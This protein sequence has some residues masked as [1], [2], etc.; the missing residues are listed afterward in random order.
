MILLEPFTVPGLDKALLELLITAGVILA[1]GVAVTVGSIIG[2]IRALRRQRRGDRSLAA[3]V[4]A[5]TAF[6][7][8]LAW[9]LYW[10]RNDLHD[11]GNPVNAMFA[12]NAA[13]CVLPLT[14]LVAAIRA[15]RARHGEWVSQ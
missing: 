11:K 4:M 15:N 7:I 10:V 9:L 6:V 3:V 13:L 14:W 8:T 5:A 2:L 1:T 12:I